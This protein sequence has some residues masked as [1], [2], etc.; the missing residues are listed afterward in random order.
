MRMRFVIHIHEL[1]NAGLCVALRR[2]ERDVAEQLL[3]RAE[4]RAIGEQVRG[5]GVAERVGVKIPIDVG[6]ARVFFYDRANGAR[7]ETVSIVI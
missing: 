2:R 7:P 1:L 6:E 3:N 4:V 5:E